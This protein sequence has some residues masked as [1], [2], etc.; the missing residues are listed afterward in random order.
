MG[1]EAWAARADVEFAREVS[2]QLPSN[3]LVLTHNPGMFHVWGANAAQL[4]IAVNDSRY[5]PDTALQRHSGGVYV[6]WNFW[7]NVD[8]PLQR[9]FCSRVLA[10]YPASVFH[11][12]RTRN[13]RFAFYRIGPLP[14]R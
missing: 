5:V 1:E 8:D 12:R 11:E 9:A 2:R 4:S 10:A 3:A 14:A 6:H 7:C 13:Y